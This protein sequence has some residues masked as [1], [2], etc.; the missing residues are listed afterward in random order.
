MRHSFLLGTTAQAFGFWYIEDKSNNTQGLF[1]KRS[2]LHGK[3]ARDGFQA[4]SQ[5]ARRIV[6]QNP[7][8]KIDGEAAAFKTYFNL[9]APDISYAWIPNPFRGNLTSSESK[10]DD[11]NLRLVDSTEIGTALPLA[12]QLARNATFIMTWDDNQDAL[13][14]GWQ[15]GTNLYNAYREFKAK[16]VPF[17][18]V[19]NPSTFVANNYTTKPAFFGCN[20]N[21]TTKGDLRAPIVAWFASAPYSS[22]SNFSY[23]QPNTSIARVHDIWVNSFNQMTQGNGTLD[24]EWPDCLGCAAID[25]SLSKL[26]PPM[27]RTSQCERCFARYCWDGVSVL[28]AEDP[29]LVDPALVLNSSERYADWYRQVGEPLER[30]LTVSG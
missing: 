20:A 23:F 19:P 21:L 9:S 5:L 4:K 15:N 7:P 26:N 25:R 3:P 18:V 22:Y 1:P 2:I 27:K 16:D 11:S 17:P 28:E 6:S 29:E 12:G 13:P 24:D 14:Y 30:S 8:D 10:N